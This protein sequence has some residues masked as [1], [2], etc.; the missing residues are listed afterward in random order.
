MVRAAAG[1]QQVHRD[2]AR[3]G[4]HPEVQRGIRGHRVRDRVQRRILRIHAPRVA[5]VAAR[6]AAAVERDRTR[7][8]ERG[9]VRIERDVG[10][11]RRLR[12]S[13]EL[14]VDAAVE[15]LVGPLVA[16]PLG[17]DHVTAGALRHRAARE[18]RRGTRVR[19]DVGIAVGIRVVI[20]EVAERLLLEVAERERA[21]R[22][23]HE[24]RLRDP[25]TEVRGVREMRAPRDVPEERAR[26]GGHRHRGPVDGLVPDGGA[27][28]PGFR[29]EAANVGARTD[30]L[31]PRGVRQH[32]HEA[33]AIVHGDVRI[34][35][36]LAADRILRGAVGHL[37]RLGDGAAEPVAGRRVLDQSMRHGRGRQKRGQD[38]A[39][40]PEC[41]TL[42]DK[43]L[44]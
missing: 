14:R 36:G 11:D 33:V 22:L 7:T 1:H 41:V 44:V 19:R 28:I 10:R 24:V 8:R 15:T 17:V 20:R 9:D 35:E 38:K 34:V 21:P 42:H 39:C 29:I 23:P 12:I 31:S 16:A 40:R 18:E 2:I 3:G 4:G 6:R 43:S 13:G 25:V 37:V 30:A 26:P 32:A 27:A 5:Q